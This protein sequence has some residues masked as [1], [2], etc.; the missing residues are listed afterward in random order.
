M[1]QLDAD[2]TGHAIQVG[3]AGKQRR[4]VPLGD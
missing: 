3:V 2:D 1:V 4:L